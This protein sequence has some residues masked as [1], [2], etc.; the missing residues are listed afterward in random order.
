MEGF[1]HISSRKVYLIEM[2]ETANDNG[3]LVEENPNNILS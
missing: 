2:N 3:S 1:G